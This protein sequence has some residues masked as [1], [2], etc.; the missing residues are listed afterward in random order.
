MGT[1]GVVASA[2]PLASAAGLKV[3]MDGGNAVDASVTVA[4]ILSIDEP[5]FSGIGG[6]G[7]LML[8][9]A[10][11]SEVKYLDFGGFAPHD[12]TIDQ[13]GTPPSY[14]Y[15]DVRSSVFPGTL[16][17]WAE[18]LERHGT[19]SL[20][21]TLEPAIEHARRG[22]PARP[23]VV[24]CIARL[25]CEVLRFPE[26]AGIIL[27]NEGVFFDL[28]PL[29]G[30]NYPAAGKRVQHDMSP[31]MVFSG[32]RL[33][34]ALGTPGALGITQT[35]PQVISKVIDHGLELQAAIES[36]RYRYF[37]AGQVRLGENIPPAIRDRLRDAGHEILSPGAPPIWAGG[38]HAVMID[39]ETGTLIGGADPR[40]GGLAVAY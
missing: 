18:V 17:G 34:L 32:D 23:V 13:W 2:S 10:D 24:D 21:Q 33:F 37:G 8:H 3:L 1:R 35:I 20:S 6:H 26:L 16:A 22:V 31:T 5:Y 11:T 19:R 25:K 14:H 9:L 29:D 12:F 36:D 4:S 30:P 15:W 28:D 7:I 39:P 40:R 38:F 27:N